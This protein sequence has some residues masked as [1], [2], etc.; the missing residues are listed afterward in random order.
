MILTRSPYYKI[1]PWDISAEK[2]ILQI[3]VWGGLKADTP[4][5]PTHEVENKNP[6]SRTGN[7]RVN[8][9]NLIN[10]NLTVGL[11]SDTKTNV[12]DSNSAVWVKTQ[13]IDYINGV[14][15]TPRLVSTDLAVK[16][17]GY[18]IEGENTTIP[19]N[20]ILAFGNS[21]NVSYNSNFTLPIKVSET[22]SVNVSVQLPILGLY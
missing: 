4:T 16:G 1:I 7:S 5:N 19:S 17:F 8:I 9:S 12:I 3:Y 21:V 22:S 11:E 13:V 15:Q 6:L 14:A 18:G 20:N 2:Y 10:D